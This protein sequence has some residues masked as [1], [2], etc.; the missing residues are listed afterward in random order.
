MKITT[1]GRSK[2]IRVSSGLH[3]INIDGVFDGTS[4]QID[5]AKSCDADTW[6]PLLDEDGTATAITSTFNKQATLGQGYVSFV[7]TGGGTGPGISVD[8]N[9]SHL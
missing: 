6:S 3:F 1:T 7:A 5:W 4:V 8:V 9:L 2:A